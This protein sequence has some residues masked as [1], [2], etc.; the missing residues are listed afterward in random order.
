MR[1][2]G[3]T[4]AHAEL[5]RDPE[6]VR[7]EVI[8][9]ANESGNGRLWVERVQVATLPRINRDELSRRDDPIGEVLR[10]IATFRQDPA[11]LAGLDFVTDLQN[12]LPN[13]LAEG[14]QP[15]KVDAFMLSTAIE[16]AEAV[17]L[18]RLSALEVL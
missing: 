18:P 5:S 11:S 13:E 7:N 9:I 4:D 16:E 12:K 10:V 6:Q 14:A 3:P 8:S 1:I 2:A 17:L 15:I